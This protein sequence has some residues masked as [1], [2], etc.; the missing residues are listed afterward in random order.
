MK[1]IKTYEELTFTQNDTTF[2]RIGDT[3]YT[4]I[5]DDIE[6]KVSF[7]KAFID[8][9]NSCWTREY[10]I[11]NK[12]IGFS[13]VNKNPLK[14]VNAITNVTK[15]FLKEKS[16]EVLIIQ[17][18]NMKGENNI[19]GINKR[20]KI[21]SYYLKQLDGYNVQYLDMISSYSNNSVSTMCLLYKHGIDINPIITYWSKSPLYK[22][23]EV[24]Y[25]L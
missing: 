11:K 10:D 7:D 2:K 14:I 20:A 24:K 19:K 4:T 25:I 15:D 22:Y 9:Y 21:N 1:F 13:Q 18:V 16:V 12:D 3:K 17:H 6:Y 8:Y 5:V 23:I